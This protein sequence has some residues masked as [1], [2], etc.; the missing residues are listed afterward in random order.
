MNKVFCKAVDLA[1]SIVA[2]AGGFG[3]EI[4]IPNSR[5]TTRKK[6]C[7]TEFLG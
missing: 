6:G 4:E 5:A 1:L 2:I 7:D 3:S